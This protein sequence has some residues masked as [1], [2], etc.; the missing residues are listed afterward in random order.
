MPAFFGKN[1][2]HTVYYSRQGAAPDANG[3]ASFGVQSSAPCKLHGLVRRVT[4]P[5]GDERES[6]HTIYTEAEIKVGDRVWCPALGDD[7]ANV[8]HARR[9]INV[10]TSES[11]AGG[12]KLVAVFL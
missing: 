5:D 2:I 10:G 7:I 4:D 8:S 6:H 3:D 1:L 9:P 11:L 12:V